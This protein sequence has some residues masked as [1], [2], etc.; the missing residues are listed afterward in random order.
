MEGRGGCWRGAAA[1]AGPVPRR[2]A[3]FGRAAPVPAVPLPS[4]SRPGTRELLNPRRSPTRASGAGRPP[5]PPPPPP[6]AAGDSGEPAPPPPA[7]WDAASPAPPGPASPGPPGPARP[8]PCPAPP[9]GPPRP[10]SARPRRGPR[11]F[12]PQPPRRTLLTWA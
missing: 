5:A 1:S 7:R 11:P 2:A 8:P 12:L 4:G 10:P 9:P 6:R 3:L